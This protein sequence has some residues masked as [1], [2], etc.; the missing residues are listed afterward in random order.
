MKKIS[1]VCIMILIFC[2]A[3]TY[4]KMFRN[5]KESFSTEIVLYGRE[6][7]SYCGSD[8]DAFVDVHIYFLENIDDIEKKIDQ[9]GI[10]GL[11]L[12]NYKDS[13][14][15]KYEMVKEIR[16]GQKKKS[17][18]KDSLHCNYIYVVGN[19][20]ETTESSIKKIV[21]CS[22]AS[23]FLNKVFSSP[24]NHCVYIGD[25]KLEDSYYV[26]KHE[27]KKEKNNTYK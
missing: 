6:D 17:V 15:L 2:N 13:S 22:G 16:A 26:L 3:C 20:C 4:F 7:L 8:P 12:T 24:C 11:T 9:D 5:E 18:Y 19:F 25:K 21:N 1:I 23:W 10:D 14:L 27:K